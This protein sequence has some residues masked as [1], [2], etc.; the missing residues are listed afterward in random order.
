VLLCSC[1]A[2]L[3]CYVL[4]LVIRR[5]RHTALCSA[6]FHSDTQFPH[7]II[8]LGAVCR[9]RVDVGENVCKLAGD[10]D[11]VMFTALATRYLVSEQNYGHYMYRQFNIQQFY[12]LHTQCIYVFCL[13]LRTNS[14][15]FPIQ[16]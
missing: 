12:V 13:D 9:V 5:S 2:V 8:T 15:Y 10:Q 14:D 11:R 7:S 1:V 3:L 4:L 16:H 6:D